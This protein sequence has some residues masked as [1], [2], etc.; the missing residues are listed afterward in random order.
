MPKGSVQELRYLVE[1]PIPYVDRRGHSLDRRK[2]LRWQ[3][4]LGTVLTECFGGFTPAKAAAMN[5]VQT[6]G[7]KWITLSE[8]GQ[9]LLRS[10]CADRNEFLVHRDRLVDLV[11]RMGEDLDQADVFILAYD[12]DSLLIEVAKRT[13]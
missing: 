5:R 13:H 8:K 4:R 1:I 10:A 9:I 7:G 3:R 11:V 2:R 6:A 12:S